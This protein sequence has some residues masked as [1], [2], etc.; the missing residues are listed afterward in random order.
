MKP[1]LLVLAAGMGSRYGGL[2][3]MEPMGPAGETILDY[4]VYDACRAGFDKVVFVIRRDFAEDFK[5]ELGSR[6]ESAIEVAY[7][8]QEL[9]D[10]PTCHRI[11][12]GRQKPWGTAH[13]VRAARNAITAPFATVNADDFYGR[14]AFVRIG[15]YLAALQDPDAL[16]LAMVGYPLRNTLSPH[17]AVNRGLCTVA[18]GN[19][20]SVAEYEEIRE[21][22][23]TLMGNDPEGVRQNVDAD[24]LV[25]MNCWGF[26]PA[27]FP[28][29]ETIFTN[30]LNAHAGELKSECYIP[31]VVD[32]LIQSGRA[33]CPVLETEGAWFGVTYPDD[34]PLVQEKLRTLHAA[35][36]YPERLWA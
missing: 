17:G 23:D 2:K 35:G 31:A 8:F 22:A 14:D 20:Q 5:R 4:T 30:F 27:L 15:N 36:A 13:A 7:A 29:L 21:E 19:L 33:T 6:F 26:T 34:K 25:S 1:S 12:E 9:G 10:I 24:T 11:P 3:Q 16:Q 32:E 28:A 18:E